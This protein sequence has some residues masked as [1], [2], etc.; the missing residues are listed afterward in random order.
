M[1]FPF[2]SAGPASRDETELSLRTVTF[3]CL[4]RNI[5]FCWSVI[6]VVA[7]PTTFSCSTVSFFL[8]SPVFLL[9]YSALSSELKLRARL[10]LTVVHWESLSPI[11]GV[12]S[13]V[14]EGVLTIL[15]TA[16]LSMTA[17]PSNGVSTDTQAVAG[18]V[19][20]SFLGEGGLEAVTSLYSGTTG[21]VSRAG[22]GT[23]GG[24]G[25]SSTT[26]SR[27]RVVFVNGILDW[28]ATPATSVRV[29]K[30]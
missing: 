16:D 29:R 17:S 23:Y 18:S 14:E 26:G 8:A 19:L 2:V 11:S 27:R 12:C 28:A 5:S 25:C 10:R 20:F 13:S 7:I 1:V 4:R 6:P 21:S 24:K 30:L 22:L 3:C 15:G 9:L